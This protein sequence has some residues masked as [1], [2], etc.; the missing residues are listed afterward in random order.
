MDDHTE[1]AP[2][3]EAPDRGPG[4]TDEPHAEPT[5]TDRFAHILRRAGVIGLGLSLVIHVVLLIIAASIIFARQPGRLGGGEPAPFVEFAVATAEELAEIERVEL[6][7]EQP[8]TA[9]LPEPD[10]PE[11]ELFDLPTD[12]IGQIE[13]VSELASSLGAGDIADELDLEGG[14]GSGSTSF[15]GVE[16]V[17]RR[18]AF[19]VDRSGSMSSSGKWQATQHE[20]IR[21]VDGMLEN[22]E[23]CVVLFSSAGNEVVL[24]GRTQ[25]RD[26]T[27]QGKR[28]A[29]QQVIELPTPGGGTDPV[30]AF[31]LVSQ[32]RPRPDAIYFMTDGEFGE[33]LALEIIDIDNKLDVPIHCITFV[34]DQAAPMMRMIA[35]RS[36]GSYTHVP[37][38]GP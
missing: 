24:G 22:A 26:A 13:D 29:R 33:A 6:Q 35:D 38:V 27:T 18:F 37:G 14:G 11:V 19:V 16:A 31:E 2:G 30:P 17:G 9:E 12:V 25:W 15:F 7:A 5:M 4:P 10:L 32:L 1:R 34:N 21:A 36:G 23:F 28:W 20:M 8:T 3:V